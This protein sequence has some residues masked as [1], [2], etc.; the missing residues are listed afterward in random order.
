MAG[1][2]F[3]AL[4]LPGLLLYAGREPVVPY[5]A[6]G[7]PALGDGIALHLSDD[8]AAALGARR[9]ENAGA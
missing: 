3:E 7:T 4:V 6:P 1:E 9:R 8:A 5:G 2:A